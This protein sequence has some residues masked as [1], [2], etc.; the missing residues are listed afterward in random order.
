MNICKEYINGTIIGN[1]FL[2]SFKVQRAEKC[3]TAKLRVHDE[4]LMHSI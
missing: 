2:K 1:V 3:H 4:I